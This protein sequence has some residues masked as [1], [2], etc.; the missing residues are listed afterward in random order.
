MANDQPEHAGEE[1]FKTRTEIA[2]QVLAAIDFMMKAC[3]QPSMATD[4]QLLKKELA[5]AHDLIS[6]FPGENDF[7]SIITLAESYLSQWKWKEFTV[8][9]LSVLRE[10]FAMARTKPNILF[11]DYEAVRGKF[12]RFQM[13]TSPMIPLAQHE[14]TQDEADEADTQNILS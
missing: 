14:N 8:S 7:R 11:S 9:R 12:R 6:Y 1:G 13:Q 10:V 3:G 2:D 5:S 4:I